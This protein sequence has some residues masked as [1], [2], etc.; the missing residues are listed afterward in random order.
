M[1]KQSRI[2]TIIGNVGSGKTTSLPFITQALSADFI[3]ADELFQV[4]PFRDHYLQDMHRWAFANELWLVHKRGDLIQKTLQSSTKSTVVIDS[5][6][7]MSWAYT[8]GHDI[9]QN[10]TTEE[11][12]F[13]QEMFSHLARPM[14][15][16]TTIIYLK[17]PID[18]CLQRIHRRA[19]DYELKFYTK[20]YLS[21][22]EKGLEDLCTKFEPMIG[23]LITIEEREIGNIVSSKKDQKEFSKLIKSKMNG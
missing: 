8:K 22:I 5:G 11:W 12:I 13:F 7:F 3:R 17:C 10:M 14:L 2:V 9:S 20:E 21:L 6:L 16:N 23:K 4:S 15:N 1:K 19:R 18:I